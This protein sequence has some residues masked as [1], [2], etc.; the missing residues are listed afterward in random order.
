[1]IGQRNHIV[2]RNRRFN[3]DTIGDPNGFRK[4]PKLA[5]IGEIARPA[6]DQAMG[7]GPKWN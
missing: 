6:E 4:L 5:K 3:G 7:L 2:E 1:M